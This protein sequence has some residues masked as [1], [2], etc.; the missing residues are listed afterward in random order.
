MVAFLRACVAFGCIVGLACIAFL[1]YIAY[2]EQI[3]MTKKS[4]G[5][6]TPDKLRINSMTAICLLLVESGYTN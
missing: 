3:I 6:N 2:L 5:K 1:V 4:G